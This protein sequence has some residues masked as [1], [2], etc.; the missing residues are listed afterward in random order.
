MAQDVHG[1]AKPARFGV[2]GWVIALCVTLFMGLIGGAAILKYGPPPTTPSGNG[3]QVAVNVTDPEAP[4]YTHVTP[5]EPQLAAANQPM[6]VVEFLQGEVP[7]C[8][9]CK[10]LLRVGTTRCQDCGQELEQVTISCRRCHGSNQVKCSKCGGQGTFNGHCTNCGGLKQVIFIN[11]RFNK[12]SS[13]L[14]PASGNH[15]GSHIR[16]VRESPR[17]GELAVKYPNGFVAKVYDCPECAPRDYVDNYR[18]SR[19]CGACQ[20]GMVS[21]PDCG[22]D[23]IEGN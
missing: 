8:P 10:G 12:P 14:Y 18:I 20:S 17:F 15:K 22:G 5:D 3:A 19:T 7:V 13:A 6:K 11:G 23:G 2:P 16:D 4:G 9:K 1:S 21:C